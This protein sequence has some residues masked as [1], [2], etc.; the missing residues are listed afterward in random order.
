MSLYFEVAKQDDPVT[1]KLPALEELKFDFGLIRALLSDVG[2]FVKTS[3]PKSGSEQ[4]PCNG[5]ASLALKAFCSSHRECRGQRGATTHPGNC[6]LSGISNSINP[7]DFRRCTGFMKD[8][9]HAKALFK[10]IGD[11]DDLSMEMDLK[12]ESRMSSLLS[13]LAEELKTCQFVGDHEPSL[14]PQYAPY[15]QRVR[16]NGQRLDGQAKQRLAEFVQIFEGI[17]ALFGN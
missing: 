13:S 3:Q 10:A 1:E 16:C 8:S 5:T 9:E 15:A 14:Q 4:L 6:M 2:N 12:Q 7:E 17:K 11:F